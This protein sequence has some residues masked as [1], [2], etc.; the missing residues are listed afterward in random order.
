MKLIH[1]PIQYQNEPA[2]KLT[3]YLSD[4]SPEIELLRVRPAVVI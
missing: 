3:G 2:A 4:N 1:Q